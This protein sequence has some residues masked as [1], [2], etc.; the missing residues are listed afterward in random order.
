M[1]IEKAFSTIGKST[2]LGAGVGF[3]A[4]VS[5][6]GSHGPYI[7]PSAQVVTM[8]S[9]GSIAGF[10]LGVAKLFLDMCIEGMSSIKPQALTPSGARDIT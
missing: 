3:F 1:N 5:T 6:Y 2:T 10:S 8:M 9:M 7:D 4:G